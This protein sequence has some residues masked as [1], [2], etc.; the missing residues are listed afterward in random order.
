MSSVELGPEVTDAAMKSFAVGVGYH[1]MVDALRRRPKYQRPPEV[2]A[3]L[4]DVANT[5]PDVIT[6]LEAA[7]HIVDPASAFSGPRPTWA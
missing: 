3:L 7:G 4:E 6:G 5:A 1:A 2:V